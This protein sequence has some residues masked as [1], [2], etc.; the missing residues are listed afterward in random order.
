MNRGRQGVSASARSPFGSGLYLLR[1]GAVWRSFWT[2]PWSFKL[3]CCYV[4]L[5]YVRPQQLYPVL[6]VMPW[7]L[8][9]IGAA[10]AAFVIEGRKI[11]SRTAINGWL[12]A[13][14]VLVLLSSMMAAYP[15]QS[16][17]R[18][19]VQINWLIAFFLIANTTT[20]Q[21]KFLLFVALFLLWSTKMSQ[22]GARAFLAGGGQASGAP[23]WFQNTGEF[24][25]QMCIYVPLSLQFLIGLY[26][27][28][29]KRTVVVLSLLP[30]TGIMSIVGSGSRGGLLALACV[31][32]WMLLVGQRRVRGLIAILAVAPLVWFAIPAYQKARLSTVGT[33]NTSLARIAYWKAGIE[34]ANEHPLLGVGYENWIPYYREHYP[35]SRGGIIRYGDRGQ[36]IVEVSHNSF[37]EVLSQL[38][39]PALLIFL[40]LL[41]SIW[42]LNAKTRRMLKS[43]DERARFLRHVSHGLDAGVVGFIVA[44]FFMAVAFYPFVWFQLGMTAALHASAQN[45][46]RSAGNERRT[47]TSDHRHQM[48]LASRM[49]G[50][51]PQSRR[52]HT[53]LPPQLS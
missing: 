20:D 41:S 33:D 38:G 14:T 25:L 12:V 2:E 30:I 47:E 28:L 6:Q 49:N 21:R 29:P 53:V 16:F 23:G 45:L 4:F 44:G 43:L 36:V 31:G 42:V 46:I 48:G 50:S 22:H 32:L 9:S 8:L 15:V 37:V 7:P 52:I 35:P 26:P 1:V 40:T 11:R 13:F 51:W 39:Y 19:S 34:M 10:C 24:A 17:D 18:L 5:E 3:T 27:S